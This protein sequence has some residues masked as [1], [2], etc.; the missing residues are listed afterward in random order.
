MSEGRSISRTLRKLWRH[1]NLNVK[2][3]I[4]ISNVCATSKIMYSLESLWLLKAD[5]DRLDAFQCMC[6]RRTLNIAPS[7]FSRVTNKEVYECACQSKFS[8][9]LE[10]RQKKIF[11][12][13]QMMSVESPLRKLVCDLG[14]RP[15]IWRSRRKRGRPQ[16]MWATS[17]FKLCE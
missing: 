2:R 12:R 11:R 9:M 3:K 4:R 7:F 17:V 8:T 1:A 16:Q 13:I 5:R 15:I 14:G 10:A 6:L